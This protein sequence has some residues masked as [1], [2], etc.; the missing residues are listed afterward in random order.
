MTE[1]SLF[2]G[3]MPHHISACEAGRL[4]EYSFNS[5]NIIVLCQLTE[6]LCLPKL[7]RFTTPKLLFRIT[8]NQRTP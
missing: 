7:R 1:D 2:Y 8:K 5:S 4:I 3:Q 6:V